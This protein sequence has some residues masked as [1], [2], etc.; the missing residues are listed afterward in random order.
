[1]LL[2]KEEYIINRWVNI[3]GTNVLLLSFTVEEDKSCLWVMH[4]DEEIYVDHANDELSNE[5]NDDLWEYRPKTNRENFY[6]L[7]SKASDIN[8][9]I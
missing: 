7:L 4:K 5:F 8:I 2:P 1:M 9:S 6:G 3:Q